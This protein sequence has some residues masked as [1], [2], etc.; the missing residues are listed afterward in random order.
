LQT[1]GFPTERRVTSGWSTRSGSTLIWR[2]SGSCRSRD[3]GAAADIE[4]PWGRPQDPDP[5][6]RRKPVGVWKSS[7]TCSALREHY[8]LGRTEIAGL[9]VICHFCTARFSF[10]SRSSLAHAANE[11]SG[12]PPKLVDNIPGESMQRLLST[13]SFISRKLTRELLGQIANSS[14]EELEIFCSRSHFDYANK[15][16]VQEIGRALAD[17]RLKLASLH[18]PTSRDLSA[19]RE[20]G[21]PLSI[22]E[23]ERVRRIEAWTSSSGPRCRRRDSVFSHDF[24]HGRTA[25]NSD[26]VNVTPPSAPWNI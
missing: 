18:A 2:A 8:S 3:N 6:Q 17:N 9:S 24:S 5:L 1:R 23:V 13:Y 25:R 26:R 11:A 10:S 15:S 4:R 12:C 14:F 20:G 21:Q 16:E 7:A 22:C 19:T